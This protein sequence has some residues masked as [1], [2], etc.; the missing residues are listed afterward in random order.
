[1]SIQAAQRM[2]L[3]CLSLDPSADSPASQ[4]SESITGRFDDVDALAELLRRCDVVTFE[5]EFAPVAPLRA[6]AALADFD[7]DSFVPS[8]EVL[9]L[10]QDKLAQRRCYLNH[11]LNS[12]LA[13]PLNEASKIGFPLVAKSRF[14][15]YDGKGVR[16]VDTPDD[17]ASLR[18]EVD[19]SNWLAETKI[20][21]E[22]ELACMVAVHD[23][24][25]TVFPVM[26]VQNL[27]A[28]CDVTFP[29][30]D[31]EIL[32]I[33]TRL[34][35]DA[36]LAIADGSPGLFGVEMFQTEDGKVLINEIAP[37][38]HNTGHF[39][40]DWGEQSQF[41]VHVRVALGFP[42]PERLSGLRVAMA[43][44]L[45]PVGAKDD[46]WIYAL[47]TTLEENPDVRVHW[48]GKSSAKPGRK[49]GHLNLPIWTEDTQEAVSEVRAAQTQFYAAY[50]EDIEEEEPS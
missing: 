40:L 14:G 48:Y 44:L 36:A 47:A 7:E 3:N 35:V 39:S 30:E 23:G 29:C 8:L 13:V 17:L 6:A 26:V 46:Q 42:I 18:A 49:M 28:V 27:N 15:G 16:M 19:E 41:D 50:A 45:A 43:N 1:M 22:R 38:P 9:E 37:R 5:N 20:P 10:V 31:E 33:A 21:F 24:G 4:I 32:P 12:P 2:G 11:G 25:V 34:A